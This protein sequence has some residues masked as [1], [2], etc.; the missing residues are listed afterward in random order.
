MP[1]E[2]GNF[3]ITP[4]GIFLLFSGIAGIFLALY[5]SKFKQSPGIGY[6]A[7]LQFS[8]AIWTIFYFLEYSAINLSDRLFWSKLSYIGIAFIPVWFYLFSVNFESRQKKVS[9][10][11]AIPLIIVSSIFIAI[12]F[13]NDYHHLHWQSA[14]IDKEYQTTIYRYGP[15]FWLVF[16][17]I[18]GFLIA[19]IINILN[20]IRRY[21][22]QIHSA[23]WLMILACLIPVLGNIMYVFKLNPVPGFDWTPTC[24][25]ATSSILAYINIRF[26]LIDLIPFARQKLIDVMDDGFLLI[27]INYRV[28]DINQSLLNR[29]NQSREQVL[30]KHIAE[31]FPGREQLIEQLALSDKVSRVEI[32]TLLSPDR[33]YLDMRATPIFDKYNVMSGQVAIFRDITTLKNHET[34][35]L[36][37]N[38]H[39]KQEITEKE[40]LIDDLDNFANTVAHDLKN[41]IGAIVSLSEMIDQEISEKN[42]ESLTD[43]NKLIF[44]SASKTLYIMEEL[45]TMSTIRQQDITKQTVDMNAA[46][47]ESITRLSDLIESS[48]TTIIK[49]EHW[50]SAQAIPSWIEEVWVNFISNAVK[51]GGQPPVIKMGAEQLYTENKIK[52]WIKDNG[53]GLS[54]EDQGKLFTKFTRL[55]ASRAHGTG[56][57]LSIVKR[58]IEK[59]DGE[60][61]VFSDAIPGEGCLFY[62]ILPGK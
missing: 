8:T 61:G 11:L 55:E 48:R 14:A 53:N 13:T 57:G 54:T 1:H 43:L 12:V 25:F 36:K 4:L 2:I 50:P 51:Y 6:L 60:V 49:P 22:A 52:Y 19:G 7:M 59:L 10:K 34:T 24:F 26:G 45:L 3:L 23:V 37:T 31:V 18:Y 33:K 58:I 29:I 20:L 44:G 38:S 47:G 16:V 28:A 5:I 27:D 56:L 41:T 32:S 30:G 39:L 42:Y 62:F 9:Q 15:F 40:K 21:S 35:I 46:V 17:Y